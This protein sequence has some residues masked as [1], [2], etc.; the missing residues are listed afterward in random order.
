MY[1]HAYSTGA[2][3][4][5]GETGDGKASASG[6][7]ARRQHRPLADFRAVLEELRF[8][9]ARVADDQTVRFSSCT[10]VCVCVCAR[11]CVCVCVCVCACVRAIR[12][13]V[14]MYVCMYVYI[15]IYIYMY[16]YM[17]IYKYTYIYTHTKTCI[18][19]Y[20]YTW[21]KVI[22]SRRAHARRAG[23]LVREP[24][25][26]VRA[27]PPIKASISANFTCPRFHDSTCVRVCVRE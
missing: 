17:Y 13:Y 10:C 22:R 4:E 25:A 21:H 6:A 20:M 18:R 7:N 15:C 19:I 3:R 5:E 1:L 9:K 26:S 27:T 11:A 24:E 16:I 2:T 14:H 12:V 23:L 8:A